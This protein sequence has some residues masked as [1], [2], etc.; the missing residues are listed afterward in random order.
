[1]FTQSIDVHF[2]QVHCPRIHIEIIYE[3]IYDI[4]WEVFN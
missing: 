3:L 4:R 1:M 2:D